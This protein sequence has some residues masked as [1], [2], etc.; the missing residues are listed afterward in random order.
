MET[1]AKTIFERNVAGKIIRLNDPEY[2]QFYT[3]IRKAI[4]RT[5][6]LYTVLV[7]D[8]E[9]V[10]RVFIGENAVVAAGAVVTEDVPATSIVAICYLSGCSTRKLSLPKNYAI[11]SSAFGT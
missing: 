9:K 5:S 3:I 6:H 10:R 8:E 7:D 11:S 2:P 4:R 1:Q